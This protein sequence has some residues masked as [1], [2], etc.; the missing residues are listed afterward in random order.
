MSD[1]T[2]PLKLT[3]LEPYDSRLRLL[4]FV[5]QAWLPV[6][7]SADVRAGRPRAERFAGFRLVL[8]RDANGSVR[9]LEDR[10]PHRGV[11]LSLG[12]CVRGRLVCAYHGLEVDG[13]GRFGNLCVR[14]FSVREHLGM[15]WVYAGEERFANET[16]L[17]D[18]R[19]FGTQGSVDAVMHLDMRT[20]Y[21][22][23]LDNGVD[24]THDYLHRK[25]LF[26]FKVLGLDGMVEEDA[27]VEV[28]YRA[29]LR[30]EFNGSR[31]G[32]IRIRFAGP[33]VRLDFDGQ[34]I[35]HSLLTPRAANGR[36]ITQWWFVSFRA[37]RGLR[38]LYRLCMPLVRRI[39]LA[40]FGQDRRMLEKEAEAVFDHRFPQ[41]ERNPLVREVEAS[42]R[43]RLVAQSLARLPTLPVQS[44]PVPEVLSLVARGELAV[45]D[46]EVPSP[47][48]HEELTHRL[49]GHSTARVHRDWTCALIA[50]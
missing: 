27:H 6:C 1:F 18:L 35:I 5:G 3:R 4:P 25:N 14:T 33:L 31:E 46:P 41:T 34:P 36:E 22:L 20:H 42:L 50:Q 26:F 10:C 30:N 47:M 24:L 15:V 7:R 16:P 43:R 49:S 45:F 21:S 29:K 13:E 40:A 8:F 9:A 39:M 11:P 19:P 48:T 17:P 38:F 28:S 2:S 23:V 12:E 37:R 32:A 44:L